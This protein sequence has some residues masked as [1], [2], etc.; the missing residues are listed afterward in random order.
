MTC[1]FDQVGLASTPSAAPASVPS[2][3]QPPV[4]PLPPWGS[5]CACSSASTALLP[6]RAGSASIYAYYY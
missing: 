1:G 2:Q 6:P 4:S 3:P 5:L